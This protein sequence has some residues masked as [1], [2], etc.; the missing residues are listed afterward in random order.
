MTIPEF[1]ILYKRAIG[2]KILQWQAQ[3]DTINYNIFRIKYTYGEINSHNLTITYSDKIEGKNKGKSNETNSYTQTLKDIKSIY[4]RQ[5]KKGYK[6]V[7]DI[8]PNITAHTYDS[9]KN[10]LDAHLPKYNTDANNCIK[11]MK[12]Q[13]FQIGKFKYPAIAQPKINGV[14][15]CIMC[16]DIEDNI[17]KSLFDIPSE[18]K[19]KA[20]IKSKEGL[21]YNIKHLEDIFTRFYN[22]YPNHKDIVFDGELYIKDKNVTTIGGAARNISNPEHENLTFI[23]FDLSIPDY[24]Q[25]ERDII[26][27]DIAKIFEYDYNAFIQQ[28][29]QQHDGTIHHPVTFLCSEIVNNDESS[30]KYMERCKE[31]DYEGCV[32]RDLTATYQFGSRPMTMMKLKTFEDAEFTIIDINSVGN[33]KDRVGFTI[34]YTLMN[35]IN[36]SIFECNGTGTVDEKLNIIN[37]KNNYI[38][39][40][41][42]VK[43]YERT[44]N[45]LPFH[46]NVI[47]IRDYE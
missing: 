31:N 43:F 19:Y 12:C 6:S 15:A 7:E 23:C 5:K 35:D 29:P 33:P 16:E 39:K 37:N 27:F 32:I 44:K 17:P 45:G 2:N 4:E 40:Q 18:N 41:A 28:N 10:I 3:L 24:T 47:G 1:P 8:I 46:A 14:R 25:E 42:T 9:L 11:P 21:I 36:D 34:I 26:R 20:V 38:G 22:N 30:L 13:K